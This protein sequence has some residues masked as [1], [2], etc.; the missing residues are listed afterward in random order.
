ME[1][2][3]AALRP[4]PALP[5]T[6]RQLPTRTASL[7]FNPP[8]KTEADDPATPAEPV[9]EIRPPAKPVVVPLS[10]KRFQIQFTASKETHDLLRRAQDLL[11]HQIPNGDAGEVIARALKVLVR[12]LEKEKIAATDRPRGIRGTSSFG[13]VRTTAMRPTWTSVQSGPAQTEIGGFSGGL[14]N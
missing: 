6:I 8:P 12:E 3:I 5:S 11:R 1:K 4:R 9:L 10:P 7:V 2:I 14:E 13:A